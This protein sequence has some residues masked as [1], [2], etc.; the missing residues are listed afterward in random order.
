MRTFH[1]GGIASA[2]EITQASRVEELFEC[3]RPKNAAIITRIDGKVRIEEI[4]TNP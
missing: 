2:D 1:T 3:R 4:K